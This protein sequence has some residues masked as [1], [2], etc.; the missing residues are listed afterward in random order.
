[1]AKSPKKKANKRHSKMKEVKSNRMVAMKEPWRKA[2]RMSS[3][4]GSILGIVVGAKSWKARGYGINVDMK[5][6]FWIGR[7]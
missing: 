4:V 7:I 2:S 1:M 6:E 3:K 5:K